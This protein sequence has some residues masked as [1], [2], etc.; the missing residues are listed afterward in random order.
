[1]NLEKLTRNLHPSLKMTV[2]KVLQLSILVILIIL[3][4][5]T[6]AK[7]PTKK[8]ITL[9]QILNKVKIFLFKPNFDWTN[10]LSGNSSKWW[11]HK[12]DVL[13]NCL[14]IFWCKQQN[15]LPFVDYNKHHSHQVPPVHSTLSLTMSLF[16]LD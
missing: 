3:L 16:E 9:D 5:E 12:Y 2:N 7:P 1:M 15:C 14:F 11:Y 13:L 8:L 4:D 6:F 10:W